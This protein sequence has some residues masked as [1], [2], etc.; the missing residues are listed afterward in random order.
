MTMLGDVAFTGTLRSRIYDWDWF[1]PTSSAYTNQYVGVP[2]VLYDL[3]EM[4]VW[5]MGPLLGV[6]ALVGPST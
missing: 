2:K 4:V 3:R 6:A 1:Q 5:G